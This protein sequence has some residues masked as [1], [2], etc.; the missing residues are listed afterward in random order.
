MDYSK[1]ISKIKPNIALVVAF[2]K[3]GSPLGQGSGFVFGKKNILVTCNHVALANASIK[4]RFSDSEFLDAEVVIRDIEHDLA[5]LK[6]NVVNRSPLVAANQDVIQEGIPVIFSGYPLGLSNLTTHQGILSAI[7]TDPTGMTTYLI[8]GTVNSGNSGC[9]LMT[10]NGGVIGVIN[11]KRRENSDVLNQVENMPFGALSIHNVDIVK[12]YNAL[13][14]NVQL[15]MGYA[16]PCSY[17]PIHKESEK[18]E[19]KK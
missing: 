8:D 2:N 13:I 15:G 11:A 6:F 17:I 7:L 14:N 12:I 4:I 5:L 19:N 1:V 16:V 10:H 18:K 3:D 9:P